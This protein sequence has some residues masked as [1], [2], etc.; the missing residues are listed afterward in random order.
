MGVGKIDYIIASGIKQINL[1][2]T[3]DLE[4]FLKLD[5]IT[6]MQ[7][8]YTQTAVDREEEAK[9]DGST[10][11]SKSQSKSEEPADAEKDAEQ[12]PQE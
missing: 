1:R 6:P 3:L 7:T 11:S 2:D 10:D 8:S 9:K 4:K 5:E 12:S